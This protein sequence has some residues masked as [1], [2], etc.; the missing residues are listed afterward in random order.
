MQVPYLDLGELAAGVQ[1]RVRREGSGAAYVELIDAANFALLADAQQHTHYGGPID[2]VWDFSIPYSGRWYIAAAGSDGSVVVEQVAL[3]APALPNPQPTELGMPTVL[4]DQLPTDAQPVDFQSGPV[5][6]DAATGA[7]GGLGSRPAASP[8]DFGGPLPRR[9]APADPVD[10][11]S[12]NRMTEAEWREAWAQLQADIA[13]YNS[14]CGTHTFITPQESAA[15]AACFEAKGLIELRRKAL[16]ARANEL[17]IEIVPE[18]IPIPSSAGAPPSP[19]QPQ[20]PTEPESPSQPSP[21]ELTYTPSPKHDPK[22]PSS[23]RPGTRMDLSDEEAR[24]LLQQSI[25]VG[26][27]RYAFLNG[28]IYVFQPDNRG[29][30]HGYPSPRGRVP[31][32]IP[33]LLRDAGIIDNKTM[34]ELLGQ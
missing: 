2:D 32:N 24:A 23:G 8:M 15:L 16:I 12:P 5:P 11:L 6:G 1:M 4:H 19:S 30:F 26:K 31:D 29:G 3:P 34:K 13:G 28:K 10:P 17:G 27:Q 21:P 7:G 14:R 22:M 20:P 18:G 9:P 33:K 25:L